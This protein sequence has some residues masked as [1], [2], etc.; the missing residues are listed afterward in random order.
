MRRGTA[1]AVLVGAG[2][3]GITAKGHA[4]A[5]T[6]PIVVS[7]WDARASSVSLEYRHG[8]MKGGGFN[9][10][11]YNANFTST[12]GKLSAQFGLH[13]V[14]FTANDRDPTAHGLAA[15]A[16]ALFEFPVARRYDNG[17]PLAA[18]DFFVGSAPTTLVSGSLNYVTI[19][20]VIG[21]GVP[22]TPVKALSI[23][24]WFELSPSV[25]L[26][27][28]IKPYQVNVAD[29]G[30][31]GSV[32]PNGEI[33]FTSDQVENVVSQSVHFNTTVKAGARGGLDLAVHLSDYVDLDA[34]LALSTVGAAFTGTFVTYV[35]GGLVWRWD[36]IVPAVLPADRRLLHEDCTD[37]EQ[38]FRACP[39]SRSW[40]RPED[41]VAPA[42][43]PAA[44]A[45]ATT[46]TPS[47]T[48]PPPPPPPPPS[49]A[50]SAPVG[51]SPPPHAA[52]PVGTTSF[53]P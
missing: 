3:L 28:E 49:P 44:P 15:T 36:D 39:N 24:P 8:F 22:V 46:T 53:P 50:P 21:V 37:V 18:I 40:K 35:G 5:G 25:N 43:S 51:S 7:S 17:L 47:A 1:L 12:T 30:G 27:T 6:H 32:G 38:R 31:G 14:N 13:Y 41:L 45:P 33:T 10:V 2:S 19:P 42:A 16:T 34:N 4:L 29:L 20:I 26:D 23:T 11:A 52:P 48:P 9:D